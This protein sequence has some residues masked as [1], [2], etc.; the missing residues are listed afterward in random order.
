MPLNIF[1]MYAPP[2]YFCPLFT[3]LC[4][5]YLFF[6]SKELLKKINKQ[7]K[8]FDREKWALIGR[9]QQRALR[10]EKNTPPLPPLP[11]CMMVGVLLVS[12]AV[13]SVVLLPVP[14]VLL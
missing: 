12:A 2:G 1:V 7:N 5:M 11:Q 3:A 9:W 14:L 10:H 13:C 4:T 8:E 6:H